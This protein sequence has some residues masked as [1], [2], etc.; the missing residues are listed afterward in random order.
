MIREELCEFG[1]G[2]NRVKLCGPGEK[3]LHHSCGL[4]CDDHPAPALTNVRPRVR[5]ATGSQNGVPWREIETCIPNLNHIL[6]LNDIEPLVL[7]R[8]KMAWRP[9][10]PIIHLLQHKQTTVG[11]F[12]L[13]LDIHREKAEDLSPPALDITVRSHRPKCFLGL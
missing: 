7:F 3:R 2:G 10:L 13:H 11:V 12:S 9:T 1:S 5:H 4:E 6:P 8:M